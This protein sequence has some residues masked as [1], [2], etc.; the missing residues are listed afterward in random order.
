MTRLRSGI[1]MSREEEL[2][3][4][5][6]SLAFLYRSRN[7]IDMVEHQERLI[8]EWCEITKRPRKDFFQTSRDLVGLP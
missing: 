2:I 7:I 4:E 8:I 5:N 3:E 1:N 6:C